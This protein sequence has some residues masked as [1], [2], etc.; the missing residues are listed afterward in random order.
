MIKVVIVLLFIY[1]TVQQN[2]KGGIVSTKYEDSACSSGKEVYSDLVGN[3]LG[4]CYAYSASQGNTYS[5]SNP[6]GDGDAASLCIYNNTM[7][8]GRCNLLFLI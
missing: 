5:C 3:I 1:L 8:E 6:F 7:C 2:S 4:K